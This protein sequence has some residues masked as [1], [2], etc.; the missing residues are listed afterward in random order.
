[1]IEAD[2]QHRQ[3]PLAH[4]HLDHEG[5]DRPPSHR[6]VPVLHRGI[7]SGEARPLFQTLTR[8][9]ALRVEGEDDQQG[10]GDHLPLKVMNNVVAI[11]TLIIA[12]TANHHPPADEDDLASA[13]VPNVAIKTGFHPSPSQRAE[14]PHQNGIETE[15]D[16]VLWNATHPQLEDGGILLLCLRPMIRDAKWLTLR[17]DQNHRT[18]A[19]EKRL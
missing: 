13:S 7:A 12:R 19:R 14:A 1:M 16:V 2:P 11:D 3:K 18:Q 8:V 6:A 15:K 9:L 17:V 4:V 5:S 10:A